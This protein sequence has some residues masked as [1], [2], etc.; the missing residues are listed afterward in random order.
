MRWRCCPASLGASVVNFVLELV[1]TEDREFDT[2]PQRHKQINVPP[3][4][5][6]P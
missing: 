2:L 4:S 5:D 6:M 3:D 1:F